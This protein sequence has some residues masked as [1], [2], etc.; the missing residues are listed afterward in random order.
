MN[1]VNNF[2]SSQAKE[3]YKEGSTGVT[4]RSRALA[5]LTDELDK[6]KIEM[7]EKGSSMT[8]GAPLIKIKQT[9]NHIK[10]ECTQMDVRIGVIEHVLS[11]AQIR[12]KTM[13]MKGATN[14]L[15]IANQINLME[16]NNH[17]ETNNSSVSFAQF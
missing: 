4:E 8:D 7:E 14:G 10:T 17:A 11:Q 6:V 15:S 12:D 13:L 3:K 16:E 1:L 5:E 9:L 2:V